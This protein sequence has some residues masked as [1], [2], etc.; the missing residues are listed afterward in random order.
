M[1]TLG[2]MDPG[3]LA[4]QLKALAQPTAEGSA[5][6]AE[7][8]REL[9]ERQNPIDIARV[10]SDLENDEITRCFDLLDRQAQSV[11]LTESGPREQALLLLHIDDKVGSE[12]LSN[13]DPD[14]AADLLE[15]VDPTD[16]E[17]LLR[18]VEAEDAAEIRELQAYAPDTAGGLMTPEVVRIPQD[19][20]ASEV[21]EIVRGTTDAETINVLFVS[22]HEDLVGV[23]S[24]RDVILADPKLP[25]REFM[26]TEVIQVGPEEDQEEVIR[27]METYHLEALP[28]VGRTGRL[29]G[30]ITSDDALSAAGEE[31]DEDVMAMAGAGSANPTERGVLERVKARMPYL[32]VTLLGGIT[33]GWILNRLSVWLG[34]GPFEKTAQLLPLVAGLAGNVGMQSAA[35]VLRGFATGEIHRSRVRKV[36]GEE[37]AVAL[38]NGVLCGLISGLMALAIMENPEDGRFLA[39]AISVTLAATAAGTVG[40][41]LPSACERLGI[42][43]AIAAGPFITTLNDIL[44]FTIYICVV[45]GVFGLTAH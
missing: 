34:G 12:L 15:T 36:I 43:P 7:G 6:S 37:I 13:I 4:A 8:L 11:V 1:D 23:V 42:D 2:G 5:P 18:N 19:A 41:V 27:L 44:G 14:D 39:V 33:A 30:V 22:D 25:V 31:A 3:R 28:V 45:L 24:I 38:V 40:A 35:V 10:L 16:A 21:L 17:A 32:L 20:T 9:L 26:T 29:L